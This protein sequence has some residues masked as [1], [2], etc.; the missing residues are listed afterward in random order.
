[1]WIYVLENNTLYNFTFYKI[2]KTKNLRNRLKNHENNKYKDSYLVYD[3]ELNDKYYNYAEVYLFNLLNKYKFNNY[4]EFD[5]D[6]NK[7]INILQYFNKTLE[8]SYFCKLHISRY[9]YK[10]I[11]Y[12]ENERFKIINKFDF[13]IIIDN[14]TGYYNITKIIKYIMKDKIKNN[15]TKQITTFLRSNSTKELIKIIKTEYNL[16]TDDSDNLTYSLKKDIPEKYSGTYI[17]KTLFN[18][19]LSWIDT[20]YAIKIFKILDDEKDKYINKLE[21]ENKNLQNQINR[22]NNI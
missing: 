4:E 3:I 6:Y 11:E 15:R 1:M 20:G 10:E 12:K 2:G 7:L 17:H 13:N 22:L 9:Y 14:I 21:Q 16:K 18:H 19:A 8:L 5:I